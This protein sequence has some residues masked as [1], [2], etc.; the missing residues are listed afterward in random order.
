MVHMVAADGKSIAISTK[1]E[2]MQVLPAKRNAA[3]ERKSATVNEMHA[4]RL[5]E[6]GEAA[7]ATDTSDRCDFFVRKVPLFEQFVVKGQNREIT[8]TGAPCRM[9]GC[10]LFFCNFARLIG[11]WSWLSV[12]CHFWNCTDGHNLRI[13]SRLF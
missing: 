1:N 12:A 8:A 4:V 5:H 6:I 9:V 3:G 2:D 11:G 7:R 10:E 13:K